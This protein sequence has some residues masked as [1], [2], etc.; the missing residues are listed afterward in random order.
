MIMDHRNAAELWLTKRLLQKHNE[1]NNP[2]TATVVRFRLTQQKQQ[3]A[4]P[5]VPQPTN[6]SSVPAKYNRS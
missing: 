6:P 3:K 2:T 5:T 4:S 1:M